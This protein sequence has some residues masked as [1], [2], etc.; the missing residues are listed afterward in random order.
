TV[1]SWSRKLHCWG[2]TVFTTEDPQ[3]NWDGTN[4]NGELLASGTYYY[5]CLLFER[6]LEG[7]IARPEPLSGFIE[8]LTNE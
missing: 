4:Q 5:T 2:Q 8:L 6:Q 1:D 3:I 7:I